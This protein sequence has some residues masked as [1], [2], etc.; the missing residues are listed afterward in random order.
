MAI[1]KAI[2]SKGSISNII[3]Y[4]S[5]SNK[6]DEALMSGKDCSHNFEFAKE[7]METTKELYRK[8]TGR[9]YK[10]FVQSFNPKDNI[11][12]Q[13]AHKIGL[14][15]AEK[16]F[17]GF[18]VFIT[19]H[20]DKDH[21]HNHFVVNSV[22]FLNG[23]KFR[24]SN[25]E[26]KDLK[27]LS[28]KICERENLSKIDLHK[29]SEAFK[30]DGEYRLEK[31]GESTWKE[32]LRNSIDIAKAETKSIEEMKDLLKNKFDVETRETKNTI[33]YKHSSQNKSVRGNRLGDKYT[34]EGIL[35]HYKERSSRKELIYLYNDL[36]NKQLENKR[37]IKSI[38]DTKSKIQ[39]SEKTIEE[40][41][42]ELSCTTFIQFKKKKEIQ[43][44]IE[45]L[46]L[47]IKDL[48]DSKG[49]DNTRDISNILD[50]L[51]EKDIAYSN[52]LHELKVNI[53][54]STNSKEID[55]DQEKI[56]DKK[57]PKSIT[58][59]IKKVKEDR[60][61]KEKAEINKTKK[62]SMDIER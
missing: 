30:T 29:K 31:R 37:K 53:L 39:R 44:E 17:K 48:K 59:K 23:E 9:Q 11:S 10:H 51:K 6:T 50:K 16:S 25:K 46:E 58:E 36:T 27:E 21:I 32:E 12:P 33:S 42:Q 55:K 57:E 1:I 40:L 52:K 13:K 43:K 19:T 60:K 47:D 8:D 5:D 62:R 4:I 34:K 35:S 24:Y 2:N 61:I 18:E 22:S 7:Q 54:K 26:L 15:W 20:K 45:V 41:K 14:E 28:N 3:N 49:I 38:E 56:V